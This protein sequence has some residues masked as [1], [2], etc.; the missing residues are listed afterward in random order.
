MNQGCAR[1]HAVSGNEER[2]AVGGVEEEEVDV[3]SSREARR[4]GNPQVPSQAE[5]DAHELTH[6][7]FRNWCRHCMRGRGEEMPHIRGTDKV[8]DLH[9]FSLDYCF[10]GDSV[11]GNAAHSV[12]RARAVDQ[13]GLGSSDPQE[14]SR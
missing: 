2:K 3:G 11:G 7:P 13:H 5:V 4:L 10:P 14:G 6:L 12:G 8:S 1:G 9:E